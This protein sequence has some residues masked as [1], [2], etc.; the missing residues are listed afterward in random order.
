M[1]RNGF[2]LMEV[3]IA[4]FI[5]GI[6]VIGIAALFPAGIAQL[7]SSVDDV[8]GPVVADNAMAL[9]RARLEPGDFG[10]YEDFINVTEL[11][12]VQDL[13]LA[14][15][16]G[17]WPWLR[18][19]FLLGND[20]SME[21][22]SLDIFSY[23][24][25]RSMKNLPQQ[26]SGIPLATEF[27]DGLPDELDPPDRLYGIP[28]NTSKYDYT[29]PSREPRVIVTQ[30]ERYYPMVPTAV[31]A[32]TPVQPLY[33]WDCM[34]RRYQGRVYV[35]IFV[36]RVTSQ[37]GDRAGYVTPPNPLTEPPPPASLPLTLPP[38]PYRLDLIGSGPPPWP[39]AW[40][41][42]GINPSDPSDDA[43]VPGTA[44]ND[45]WDIRDPAVAWQQ[46]GQWLLDQ[47]NTVHRV[48]SRT[49]QTSTNYAVVELLRPILPVSS[50][51]GAVSFF[52]RTP[53]PLFGVENVVTHVWY[54]PTEVDL[55]VDGDG[56]LEAGVSVSLSPVYVTVRE[57]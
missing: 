28:Y 32:N 55:D 33:V 37:G 53:G 9:L 30:Q 54:I 12:Q 11:N 19:G 16:P 31:A 17:D 3:L 47:N 44:A 29:D 48:L 41:A 4:I 50:F 2:T 24:L 35:A 45:T 5:L 8:L 49:P 18:P 46:Y 43:L 40:D 52:D 42:Y 39:A 22:G 20:Q 36:Y 26:G 15:V 38:L 25:T 14:T 1:R 6:G 57:L 23:R 10:T 51:N 21:R 27:P 13:W 7:R 56:D 34:F